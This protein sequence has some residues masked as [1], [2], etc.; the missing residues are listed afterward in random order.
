MILRALQDFAAELARVGA[1][2]PTRIEFTPD[3]G[4]R[5]AIGASVVFQ[6]VAGP[7]RI[8][9]PPGSLLGEL[10]AWHRL[11]LKAVPK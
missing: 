5:A 8:V 11:Q 9:N 6:T 7:L 10:S 3:D 4:P 2:L 1:P